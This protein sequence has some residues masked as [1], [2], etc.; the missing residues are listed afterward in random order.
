M[1]VAT[2]LIVDDAGG[3]RLSQWINSKV[4]IIQM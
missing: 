4:A 1:C 3:R 2:G